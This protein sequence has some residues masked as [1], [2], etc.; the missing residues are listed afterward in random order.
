M[1]DDREPA[2]FQA[3]PCREERR[4]LLTQAIRSETRAGWRLESRMDYRAVLFRRRTGPIGPN[5]ALGVLTLGL[6]F[7]IWGVLV[8]VREPR[9]MII[10]VDEWGFVMRTER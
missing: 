2:A 4:A 7:A 8:A 6:W 3:R 9:R 5:V 1:N 10:T